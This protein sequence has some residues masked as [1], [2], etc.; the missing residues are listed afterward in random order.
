[1]NKNKSAARLISGIAI[2]TLSPIV[3]ANTLAFWN[4]NDQA[5]V[6]ARS[7]DLKENESPML[8][9]SP[10][11]I[12][13]IG[14][15][16]NN[17]LSWQAKYGSV[18]VTAYNT[19]AVTDGI[20]DQGLSVHLLPVEQA[21]YGVRDIT[22]PALSNVLWVQYMLDNYKT[23]DEALASLDQYQ[24][25]ESKI[26]EKALPSHI[27][28]QDA[29]G[30]SAMIEF[31]DGKITVNHGKEFNVM[32]NQISS[33]LQIESLKQYKPFGGDLAL[34]GELDANSRY[35]RA[36]GYLKLLPQPT[37]SSEAISGI[38]SVIRTTMVP[39]GSEQSPTR[40]V[41]T[42]DL[43]N[44]VYYFTSTNK[45]NVLWVDLKKLNL[46]ETSSIMQ[47]DPKN[48]QISGD[49]TKQFKP[50]KKS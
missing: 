18:V 26:G 50:I 42:S 27:A 30:D 33:A 25:I 14:D 19:N 7:M 13:R 16:S 8:R 21:N 6:V 39:H 2:L 15:L 12:A 10:R 4:N 37:D 24:I 47:L 22:K 1:M 49:A 31:I 38:E 35:I 34:P 23:V 40:W 36:A 32:T 44:Q 9:S 28:L 48:S 20:N 43:S 5:K 41:T 3:E 17:H 11:G 29:T 46:K 45:P